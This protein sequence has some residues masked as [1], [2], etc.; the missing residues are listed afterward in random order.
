MKNVILTLK[1]HARILHRD[2]TRGDRTAVNRA[3]KSSQLS[4]LDDPEII[5]SIRRRHCF[6]IIATELGFDGWPHLLR[7]LKQS[8]PD[9]YGTFFYPKR[10][11]VH[12]NIWFASYEEASKVRNEHGGFLLAYKN[13]F[14]VVDED[15]IRSFGLNPEDPEFEVIGR[16]WVQLQSHEHRNRLYG[17][18]VE[19]ILN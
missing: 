15:Y 2:I 5:Q 9:D 11:H 17:K 3:R 6:S 19:T 18:L 1:A 10:C 7:V 16:D 14:F 12:W 13:Q 4:G 8:Q